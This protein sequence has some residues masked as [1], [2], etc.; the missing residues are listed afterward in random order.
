MTENDKE[1]FLM[2]Y[3]TVMEFYRQTVNPRVAEIWWKLAAPDM[4]LGDFEAALLEHM[5]NEK[6]APQLSEI[7]L[8]AKMRHWPTPEAAWN[9]TPKTD[10]EAGWL[11]QETARALAACQDSLDRGDMI[12]ARMAFLETYKRAVSEAGSGPKW[13]LSEAARGSPSSRAMASLA[14]LEAHPDRA[15][16]LLAITRDRLEHI[17]GA[18]TGSGLVQ[19]G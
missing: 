2:A 15:P 14:A 5:R 6:F 4:E 3:G 18:R 8:A 1:R 17:S 7:R 16:G 9:D 12:G 10:H 11:C 19:V 13:W